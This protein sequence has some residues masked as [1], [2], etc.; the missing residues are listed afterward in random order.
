MPAQ[1]VQYYGWTSEGRSE[2]FNKRPGWLVTTVGKTESIPVGIEREIVKVLS[3]CCTH[4]ALL[5]QVV[6]RAEKKSYL[7]GGWGSFSCLP[8]DHDVLAKAVYA[9]VDG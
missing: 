2:R 9:K 3:A 5:K 8:V 1:A 7:P 6:G 4:K